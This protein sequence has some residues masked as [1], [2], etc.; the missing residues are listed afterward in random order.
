[1][2]G[3]S[4]RTLLGEPALL[5]AA[6]ERCGDRCEQR[7]VGVV[8]WRPVVEASEHLELVA[9]HDDLEVLRAAAERT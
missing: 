9:K 3:I 1:M 8:D 4:G 5:E 6:G 7:A 2:L